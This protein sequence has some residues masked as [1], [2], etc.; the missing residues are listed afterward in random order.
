MSQPKKQ[1]QDKVKTCQSQDGRNRVPL[2]TNEGLQSNYGTWDKYALS[3]ANENNGKASVN[4]SESVTETP[5]REVGRTMSTTT[6]PVNASSATPTCDGRRHKVR[7]GH[8]YKEVIV[9]A[10]FVI[11]KG[12][13]TSVPVSAIAGITGW[14]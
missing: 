3:V 4:A 7:T 14:T 13:Q 8:H 6:Q 1:P 9:V 5:R 2:S 11:G 10:Y 12:S